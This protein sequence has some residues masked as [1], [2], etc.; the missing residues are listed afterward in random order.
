MTLWTNVPTDAVFSTSSAGQGTVARFA[1]PFPI[2]LRNRVSLLAIAAV[3]LL[4]VVIT[5]RWPV[6]GG[7]RN[8]RAT[9]RAI[10]ATCMPCSS[11]TTWA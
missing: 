5:L 2:P 9:S 4:F 7:T 8:I 6:Q 1:H 10:T 3:T 11:R